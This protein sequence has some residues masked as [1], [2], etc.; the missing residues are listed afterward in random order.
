MSS[1]FPKGVKPFCLLALFVCV[2]LSCYSARAVDHQPASLSSEPANEEAESAIPTAPVVVDGTTL[3]SVRGLPTLPAEN[4]AELIAAR[5]QAL[6]EDRGFAPQNLRL[7]EVPA[8]TEM[9]GGDHPIMLIAD[10]D[11]R[12]EGVNRQVLGHVYVVRIGEVIEAFRH[13]RQPKLLIRHSTYALFAVLA[14]VLGLWVGRIALRRVGLAL[15]K[16]YKERLHDV[17]I[18]SLPILR[19][20]HI[21]K[22]LTG[23]LH[24]VLVIGA[25]I[26]T[27]ACL[28]YIL[29]LF[30]WTR[31]FARSLFAFL[32][33]PLYTMGAAI[34]GAI[35]EVMFLAVL[36]LVTW[37]VLKLVGLFFSAVER[38]TISLA[39]FD[40]V[41]AKPTHRLVRALVIAFAL[42]AAYPYIPGSNSQ[43]FKGVSLL[44][45]LIFSL[46]ST[47][48]IGNMISGYSLAY[49][50][51][52]KQGDRVKIAG[53]LGDVQDSKLMVTHLRTIK[54]EVVAVPNSKIINEEVVN[55]SALARTEGLILHTTVG[56]GYEVAW[57]Q[58]EAMLLEAAGR[59][60][61]LLR[62]PKPFVRQIE[63]GTFAVTYEI[64]A[65]CDEPGAMGERYT[66]LHRNILD[67]FNEYGVQIMTPAYEGDPEQ[68]KVVPKDRWSA[69]PAVSVTPLRSTRA[70]E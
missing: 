50:R 11:T 15:E 32:M 54:N 14:L 10:P 45:G 57:R 39:G 1:D 48:L 66:A 31:G 61:G 25:L 44:I 21:W 17:V 64:N 4:R 70:A 18:Q 13:E 49:R 67:I 23:L 65:Y 62:E 28:H 60:V 47:S 34:L 52:F 40:P 9:L 56:I 69:P 55:Y 26:A 68:A 59:T 43:A 6:A 19:A 42:V 16:R 20:K 58:V 41:W 46:G 63:L 51:S 29:T 12:L 24:L 37:Y 2:V 53:Y 35:P 27:Y 8:G 7:A 22:L 30:P 36:V 3:F 38:E 33:S 5:I